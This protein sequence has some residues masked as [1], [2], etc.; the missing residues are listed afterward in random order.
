MV[1]G[2][3][4]VTFVMVVR[5]GPHCFVWCL[6]AWKGTLDVLGWRERVRC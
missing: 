2:A 4:V 3:V 6:L 1:G 5:V